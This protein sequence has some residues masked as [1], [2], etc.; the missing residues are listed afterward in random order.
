VD[1]VEHI[2][3]FDLSAQAGRSAEGKQLA[4]LAGRRMVGEHDD[5]RGGVGAVQPPDLARFQRAEVHDR[6][7]G[8]VLANGAI[9]VFG[10]DVAGDDAQ[11]GVG[12]DEALQA[13]AD[14]ILKTGEHDRDRRGASMSIVIG[15]RP[16]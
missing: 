16:H 4:A 10:L 11:A 7:L 15:T 2:S 13:D 8:L 1:R 12:A 14:E 5:A 6:D 9:E 3:T